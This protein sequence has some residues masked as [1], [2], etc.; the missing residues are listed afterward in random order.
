MVP[1]FLS[2][3][4]GFQGYSL[5]P[6]PSLS[7]LYISRASNRVHH[8][9]TCVKRFCRGFHLKTD[10]PRFPN[11]QLGMLPGKKPDSGV[12]SIHRSICWGA[13]SGEI[14]VLRCP[15]RFC[16][17]CWAR[18]PTAEGREERGRTQHACSSSHPFSL[19]LLPCR[20]APHTLN[21]K[22][23]HQACHLKPLPLVHGENICVALTP[24]PNI[25]LLPV[26][27]SLRG[28]SLPAI[29]IHMVKVPPT[30]LA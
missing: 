9:G 16:C 26:L 8:T 4:V 27:I 28:T 25:H 1:G 24:T 13:R 10:G 7:G 18:W 11:T 30:W 15:H 5:F 20:C 2:R 29:S 22:V 3:S 21:R 6:T 19:H 14:T 23:S 17:L 12:W